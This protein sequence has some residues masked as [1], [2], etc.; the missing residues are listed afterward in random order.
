MDAFEGV[1][2]HFG[3]NIRLKHGQT[4]RFMQADEDFFVFNHPSISAT[5]KMTKREQVEEKK[6]KVFWAF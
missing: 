4:R 2:V 3:C 1:R 5:G 6:R